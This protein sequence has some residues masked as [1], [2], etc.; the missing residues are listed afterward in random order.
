MCGI[1]SSPSSTC[2]LCSIGCLCASSLA[3]W[4]H[5]VR[6]TVAGTHSIHPLKYR[7]CQNTQP[8]QAT[9]CPDIT[10]SWTVC[11]SHI[12]CRKASDKFHG[13]VLLLCVKCKHIVMPLSLDTVQG[14]WHS[15]HWTGACEIKKATIMQQQ[16]T[17]I[18]LFH[19][20][21]TVP[22]DSCIL[23][24]SSQMQTT[25]IQ[26]HTTFHTI[27]KHSHKQ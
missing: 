16:F 1:G 18:H 13:A 12:N 26:S 11:P 17:H 10:G 7:H 20:Y 5:L 21:H 9:H 3:V 15:Y 24:D 23:F 4:A 8:F 19:L 22:W 6:M 27:S 14:S 25:F 2:S